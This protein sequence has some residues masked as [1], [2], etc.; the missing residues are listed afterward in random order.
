E[1]RCVPEDG[2]IVRKPVNLSFEEAAAIPM[3]GLTAL[4]FLRKGNVVRGQ[5]VLVYG[6]SGSIGTYAVQLAK[7]FGAEVTGVCSTA[8]LDLVRS[9]RFNSMEPVVRSSL[10]LI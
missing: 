8:N 10:L 6:A 9:L 2:V 4:H 1:F 7:H 5:R 3:G